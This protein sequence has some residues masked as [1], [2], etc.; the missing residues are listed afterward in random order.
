M[1]QKKGLKQTNRRRFVGWLEQELRQAGGNLT[2]PPKFDDMR[3]EA[4]RLWVRP[5]ARLQGRLHGE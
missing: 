3:R 1:A 4:D 2:D 5:V